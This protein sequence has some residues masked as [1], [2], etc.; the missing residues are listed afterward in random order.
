MADPATNTPATFPPASPPSPV[1]A[2]AADLPI[3]DYDPLSAPERNRAA[4]AQMLRHPL[5]WWPQMGAAAVAQHTLVRQVLAD[6]TTFSAVNA[7]GSMTGAKSVRVMRALAGLPDEPRMV[8]NADGDHHRRL[9]AIVRQGF[10]R[11]RIDARD[12][13]MRALA[14]HLVAEFADTGGAELHTQFAAPFLAPVVNNFFGFRCF[15]PAMEEF[16]WAVKT[17]LT[18]VAPEPDQLRAAGLLHDA[19]GYVARYVADRRP[20]R[21][22]RNRDLLYDLVHGKAGDQLTEPEIIYHAL[23]GRVAAE[24]PTRYLLLSTIDTMLRRGLWHLARRA[25]AATRD[26]LVSRCIHEVLRAHSPHTTLMRIT[27]RPTTLADYRL[28][29]GLPLLPVVAAAN[30]DP[31]VFPAPLD[32][33]LERSNTDDHLAFGYGPHHCLGVDLALA[34]T[35][36]AIDALLRLPNLRHAHPERHEQVSDLCVTGLRRLDVLWDT[37]HE[38]A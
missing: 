30:L 13:F 12:G 34:A 15:D 35:R 32:V 22:P 38:P 14:E 24:E 10:T 27:R 23:L 4:Q 37:A 18:R 17:L 8:F 1:D 26:R 29:V 36:C 3:I 7:M 20:P 28:P 11:Q 31:A 25:D 21:P 2:L 6:P 33:D 9:R 16:C 5:T 19:F